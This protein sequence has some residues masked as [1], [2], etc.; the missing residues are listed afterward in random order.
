MRSLRNMDDCGV[1][2]NWIETTKYS[3]ETLLAA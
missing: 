2:G 1:A 3:N